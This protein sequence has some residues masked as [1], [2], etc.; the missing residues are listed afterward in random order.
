MTNSEAL[1]IRDAA[2]SL[3]NSIQADIQNAGTRQEH[4]RLTQLATEAERLVAAIDLLLDQP[5]NSMSP[6]PDL[7]GYLPTHM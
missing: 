1:A 4:M 6:V 5:Q 7:H 3:K 2:L